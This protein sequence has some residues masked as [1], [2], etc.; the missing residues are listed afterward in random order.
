[1]SKLAGLM[2]AEHNGKVIFTGSRERE[3]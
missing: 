2:F 3:N 1:M